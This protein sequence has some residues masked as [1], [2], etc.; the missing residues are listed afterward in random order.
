[1]LYLLHD[2]SSPLNDPTPLTAV[3]HI[4]ADKMIAEDAT[5]ARHEA[6]HPKKPK[7][8]YRV[9]QA[10][11]CE[12]S[13]RHS[14]WKARRARVHQ[15]LES[16]GESTFALDRFA[17]CG[18]GCVVE[19]TG[20]GDKVRLKA[21][22]CHSKH[23]EPCMRSK[24]NKIAGNLRDRLSLEANGRYRFIT[25]T[26]KHRPQ[27]LAMQIKR[28]Y[29]AFKKMRNYRE[30]KE[31]QH[32][33]AAMLE[34][35]YEAQT[36]FWHPHLHLVSE[37]NFLHKRELSAMWKQ[38]TGDSYIVDIRQMKDSKEVAHY[39]TKYISKG[40]SPTVWEIAS[41]AQEWILAT[42]GVRTMLT[43]GTWRGFKLLKIKD[44]GLEWKPVTS[45][46]ALYNAIAAGE[47]WALNL[48]KRLEEK[49][50]APEAKK[51]PDPRL[52]E[53]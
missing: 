52:F 53:N 6:T 13:F 34:V 48:I 22:Y 27:P 51:P 36:G 43:Y 17:Q 46:I 41:V 37:G 45:L 33:G 30:W 50:M 20:N 26:L 14:H 28:L 16:A 8:D 9:P 5:R 18:S 39:V 23:C 11:S 15:C 7:Y 1:M 47:V 4:I 2:P 31:S 32:G 10:A 19:M 3:E 24:G 40:T 29:Q 35:K 21:C 42:K 49:R 44:D 38:A 25:L 12:T